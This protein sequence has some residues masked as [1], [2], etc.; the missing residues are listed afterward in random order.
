[1]VGAFL[2]GAPREAASGRVSTA[3]GAAGLPPTGH[4]WCGACMLGRVRELQL[5]RVHQ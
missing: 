2:Q 1:M 4:A 3:V 5:V